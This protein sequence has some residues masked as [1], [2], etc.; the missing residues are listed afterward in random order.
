MIIEVVV[1]TNSGRREIE[2]ISENKFK[3]FL[4]SEP[5]NNNANKELIKLFRDYFKKDVK[6][7]RGLKSKKK[8]LKIGD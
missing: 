8:V 6:L 5:I 7:I 3:V 1:K 2:K 4:K